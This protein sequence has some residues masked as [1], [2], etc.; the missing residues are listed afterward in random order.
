M[1]LNTIFL[2]V[3]FVAVVEYVNGFPGVYLPNYILSIFMT[4]IMFQIIDE[5]IQDVVKVV[6]V[7]SNPFVAVMGKPTKTSVF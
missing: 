3:T 2:I 4:K 6:R 5:E 1:K 7:N